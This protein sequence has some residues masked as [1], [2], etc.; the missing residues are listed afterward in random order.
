[1]VI[2]LLISA[3][4]ISS[5]VETV[6]LQSF[7]T[8]SLLGNIY[9]VSLNPDGPRENIRLLHPRADG[10][11]YIFTPSGLFHWTQHSLTLV[12][13]DEIPGGLDLNSSAEDQDGRIW[14]YL[15]L[16]G[17]NV[18]ITNLW[19]LK[20]NKDGNNT[21]FN[22][23]NNILLPGEKVHNLH[24]L[25]DNTIIFQTSTPRLI[26]FTNSET[27]KSVELPTNSK[28]L[29]GGDKTVIVGEDSENGTKLRVLSP[30]TEQWKQLPLIPKYQP[31][32]ICMDVN[33]HIICVGD[34]DYIL[35]KLPPDSKTW[36]H[37]IT[38]ESFFHFH[39]SPGG[40][41]FQEINGLNIHQLSESGLAYSPILNEINQW[42]PMGGG[43]N[44]FF[45]EENNWILTN[46]GLFFVT[47]Q[48]KN[49]FLPVLNGLSGE[50]TSTRGLIEIGDET[51]LAGTYSGV[52]ELNTNFLAQGQ[53]NY[54]K[55]ESNPDCPVKF[56]QGFKKSRFR[57]SAMFVYYNYIHIDNL[58]TGECHLFE[59]RT[60]QNN[61][62][63]LAEIGSSHILIGSTTGLFILEMETGEANPFYLSRNES[64]IDLRGIGINRITRGIYDDTYWVSS[65]KGLFSVKIKPSKGLYEGIVLEK[66][67]PETPIH[68]IAMPGEDELLITTMNK[69]L[70]HLRK[71]ND[72][73]EIIQEFNTDNF[74]AT[75]RTHSIEIDKK[76]RAWLG[77]GDGLFLICLE[78]G[79]AQRFDTRNGISHNEFNRLAS[80]YL[81]N[82]WMV[83]GGID[84]YNF[85]KPMKFSKPGDS[86]SI[87]IN[88]FKVNYENPDLAVE[89]IHSAQESGI[90]EIPANVK[91]VTPL[92]DLPFSHLVE[93]VYYRE[94]NN[95]S[96]WVLAL[97]HQIP[98]DILKTSSENQLEVLIKLPCGKLLLGKKP[99]V[100]YLHAKSAVSG[101]HILMGVG[102]VI[103]ITVGVWLFFIHKKKAE[104]KKQGFDLDSKKDAVGPVTRE[105]TTSR[106]DA[107]EAQ[108]DE[109]QTPPQT[110]RKE[111]IK[112]S[113]ASVSEKLKPGKELSSDG[114]FD[115][116]SSIFQEPQIIDE[117]IDQEFYLKVCTI[118]EKNLSDPNF[119]VKNLAEEL[120][121]SKRKLH[122]KMKEKTGQTPHAIL[123]TIRLEKARDLL[124]NDPDLTIAE[125]TYAVGM[126]KPSYMSKIFKEKYDITIRSFKAEVKKQKRR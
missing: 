78:M 115:K 22:P 125:I 13:E 19:A 69:G 37:E 65:N 63:G 80:L 108:T 54:K 61:I 44:Y 70:L 3:S 60:H 85:F 56:A 10:T 49:E 88:A 64:Q 17:K 112:P 75:N 34:S 12:E 9:E 98:T 126:N 68:G 8:D 39:R 79:I 117:G 41:I 96:N 7:K 123:S 116:K 73:W 81:Q 31:V 51:L 86:H 11:Y 121:F 74:L 100:L 4:C 23:L 122:R 62:W 30:E 6:H 28:L 53:I 72:D 48:K 20:P 2:M 77:T 111:Q 113:P 58:K 71:S 92:P 101:A 46:N 57:D 33:E 15:E 29:G 32:D 102:L 21:T 16:F 76:G 104:E 83:F 110:S 27:Y 59:L 38:P 97:D 103:I 35:S 5:Q 36:S 1:M 94:A 95:Q 26:V 87:G 50:A 99:I 18:P 45:A 106:V 90:F 91:S 42:L 84:G 67:L 118:I 14:F 124:I 24:Q 93:S 55:I 114:H 107:P 66:L 120:G 82:G 89:V 43:K 47:L 40:G 25:Q 52:F 119:K 109:K 105:Q